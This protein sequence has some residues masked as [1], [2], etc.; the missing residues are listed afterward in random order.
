MRSRTVVVADCLSFL[1]LFAGTA[2]AAPSS[3]R[4]GFGEADITPPLQGK[5]VYLAGFGR[6]R[7]AL[8]VHDPLKA[9]AV[10]FQDDS[11]KIA[12]VSADVVG[13][14]YADVLKIREKLPGFTY[15]LVSSTHTH[16][17]PDTLGLWGPKSL[18]SG[19]DPA[20]MQFL[21]AQ[22]VRAV[23]QAEAAL[24]PMT[25]RIGTARAPELLH[26]ARE[27]YIKHD[28]LVALEFR[29]VGNNVP[30][31][32]IVQW[33]CHPETLESKN[34][35][36]SADFIAAT[37]DRLAR[38]HHCPV[39]Y[40]SGTVGG[41][42]TSMHVDVKDAR[43]KTLA[44]ASFE[45]TERYG[46]LVAELAERALRESR[47]LSLQPVEVQHREVF[48]P[49]DNPLFLMAKSLRVFERPAFAW[50]GDSRHAAPA[51]SQSRRTCLK[52]EVARLRLGELDIAAIPGEIY[53]ELVLGKVQDPPDLGADYPTAPPE[54][55]IYAQLQSRHRMIVGLANDELGYIIP[56]RQWDE[57]PPYCYGRKRPQYGEQNS[58][59]P[60]TAPILCEAFK[61]LCADK[62]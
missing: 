37:V 36:V 7:T 33:N 39:L 12:I 54:P 28:E 8:G 4:A 35:L 22:I 51:T 49:L 41:L 61:Q 15:V 40:L 44:P 11:S 6:G 9:R 16:S 3:V 13:L 59:G 42:M 45:K 29:C 1:L 26:D 43:G 27:P 53:P 2:D 52:T 60:E 21:R 20:Y 55:A 14:F 32:L 38:A 57:K 48:L 10:V 58:V 50:T 30:A 56:K 18:A 47:S 5:P 46:E 34:R 62:K 25:A 24:E 23:Q 19:V 31:G 17:G